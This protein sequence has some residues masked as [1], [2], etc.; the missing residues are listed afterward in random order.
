ME[1]WLLA[2]LLTSATLSAQQQAPTELPKLDPYRAKALENALRAPN[3]F[4]RK[5]NGSVG[6]FALPPSTTLM[7]PNQTPQLK[8]GVEAC[9]IPLSR[10]PADY[11]TDPGINRELKTD[12]RH[13][14]NMP[15]TKGL[16]PCR[17][18]EHDEGSGSAK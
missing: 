2:F 12:A 14:D 13:V 9:A 1:H 17:E 3:L 15:I 4:T 11:H 16:P 18:N 5:P 10:V 7:L 8:A 6:E